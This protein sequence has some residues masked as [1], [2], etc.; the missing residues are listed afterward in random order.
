MALNTG[1]REVAP[2]RL[3][4]ESG[5]G[6]GTTSKFAPPKCRDESGESVAGAKLRVSEERKSGVG[7]GERRNLRRRSLRSNWRESVGREGEPWL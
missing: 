2:L 5:V 4:R 1:S 6:E 3:L 7:K